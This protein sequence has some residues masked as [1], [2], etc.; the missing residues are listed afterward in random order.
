MGLTRRVIEVPV[1]LTVSSVLVFLLPQLTGTDTARAVLRARSAESTP[2]AATVARVT[3][4]FGL[5]R[6]LPEQYLSWV[7]HALSG[8]FGLSLTTRTP[9]G[10][11]VLAATGVSV[12][13][14][15]L[16]LALA[17][18]I[19]IPA[20]VYAAARRG[21]LLD[22]L[23]SAASV[24]GVAVPEFILGP[25]LVLIFSVTLDLLP[26]S[27]WGTPGQ[28]VMPTLSLAAFPAA[29]AAQLTR[30]EMLDA[31]ERPY[32][33]FARAKGITR[34]RVLWRHA[35]RTALTSVLALS[36]VFFAGLLGGAVVAEVIFAVPGLGRLLYDAVLAQDLPMTQAGLLTIITLALLARVTADLLHLATTPLARAAQR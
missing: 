6:S 30:A 36:S 7:G 11:Q 29:L 25:L 27:G 19:G 15:L 35:A 4:E 28:A 1:V 5:D 2:D 32:I 17:A 9:V 20:G 21:R 18:G 31:L 13:L 33:D 23:V 3:H 8:D 24:L 16:A 14:V 10:P 12:T 26:T 22:K 34:H